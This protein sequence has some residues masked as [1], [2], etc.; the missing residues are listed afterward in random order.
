MAVKALTSDSFASEVLN[1]NGV[2]AVRFWAEW[3]GP[4]RMM[5]PVYD[6][7][8]TKL[9]GLA[10]FAEVDIDA[11]PELASA[12]GITSIPAVVIFQAGSM[13]DHIAGV[14]PGSVYETILS[15]Y[16]GTESTG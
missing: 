1:T 3:C 14:A 9:A 16:A 13:V 8:A 11:C 10:N 12:C 5:K 4:C 2:Y 6:A 7:L 15:Q